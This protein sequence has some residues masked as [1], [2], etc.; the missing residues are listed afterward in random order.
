MLIS[1]KVLWAQV[2]RKWESTEK[3]HR[4]TFLLEKIFLLS[5]RGEKKYHVKMIASQ[6]F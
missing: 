5:K 2:A 1:T 4:V 3:D 6:L